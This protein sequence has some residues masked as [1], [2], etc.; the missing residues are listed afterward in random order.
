MSRR[1]VLCGDIGGTKAR[2][3]IAALDG[4]RPELVFE[5]H[6]ADRDFG[7]FADLV[8][9]FRDEARTAVERACLGVAGPVDGRRV[10]VTNFPWEIDADALEGIV[11]APVALANDFVAAAHGIDA[12]GPDDAV[13]LQAGEPEVRA[14]QLV[15][16]AGTGLGVAY[17]VWQDGR[18]A[19]IGGEGGH[20]GFAPADERQAEL[21]RS[22]H[23]ELGRVRAEHVVSGPGLARIHDFLRDGRGTARSPEEISSA[24][25]P[26]A[27]E[28]VDLFL[29]CY[30]AVAGDHALAI[31]ARGGVFLAGGI[32]PRLLPRLRSG[33]FLEA[34]NAK[35]VH[36]NLA[37][38]FPVK[39]VVNERLGLLGAAQLAAG[40]WPPSRPSAGASRASVASR[41]PRSDSRPP[42]APS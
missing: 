26:L 16:G 21:W 33:P 9:A 30:G 28:A 7:A 19:V 18:Y 17:R 39:V 38:R 23:A 25:D 27:R 35:G 4:G 41:T 34:F 40:P 31:L 14:P 5:R 6:Y 13:T 3:A 36:A 24:D 12:L 2:L 37:A 8:R 11:G 15:I 29:A 20:A 1:F 42:R 22:L 10:A 32:A